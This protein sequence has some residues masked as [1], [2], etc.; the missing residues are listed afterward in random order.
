MNYLGVDYGTKRIGL[1]KAEDEL[2]IAT[3][4]T[5]IPNDPN[6]FEKIREIVIREKI[7]DIVLGVPVSFDG[8]EHRFTQEVRGFGKNL[9][10]SVGLP[11]R[12]QNEILTTIQAEKGG[13]AD[14]DASAAALIL[15]SFLDVL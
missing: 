2:K 5:T 10:K 14:P 15:Q 1:A 12:F 8:K 13:S 7:S 11:V 4:L 9:E 6:I 3:P